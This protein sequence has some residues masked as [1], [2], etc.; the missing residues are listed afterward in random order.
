MVFVISEVP[1]QLV[2]FG[3]AELKLE[4][5]ERCFGFFVLEDPGATYAVDA[6]EDLVPNNIGGFRIEGLEEVE[7]AGRLLEARGGEGTSIGDHA[8]AIFDSK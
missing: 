7:D 1:S 3:A 4:A 2:G 5:F 8:S 6:S